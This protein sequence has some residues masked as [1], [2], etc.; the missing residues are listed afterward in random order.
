MDPGSNVAGL[1]TF[2]SKITHGHPWNSVR[3]ILTGFVGH[4]SHLTW[5]LGSNFNLAEGFLTLAAAT[6]ASVTG[7]ATTPITCMYTDIL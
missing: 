6:T 2:I 7:T 3:F 4:M 5:F 1:G